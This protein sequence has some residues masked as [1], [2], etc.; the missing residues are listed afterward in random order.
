MKRNITVTSLTLTL[1]QGMDIQDESKYVLMNYGPVKA[2]LTTLQTTLDP[3]LTELLNSLTKRVKNLQSKSCTVYDI[4]KKDI[5]I[6]RALHF[7]TAIEQGGTN[8]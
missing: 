1:E 3:Q 7:T 4:S 6:V 8:V 2:G 5:Q